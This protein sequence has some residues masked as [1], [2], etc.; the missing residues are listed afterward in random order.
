MGMD[1]LNPEEEVSIL[2]DG[3]SH[4]SDEISPHYY[5]TFNDKVVEPLSVKWGGSTGS[6]INP[7]I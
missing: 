6:N 7:D 1:S 4:V 5:I 3:R 2:K